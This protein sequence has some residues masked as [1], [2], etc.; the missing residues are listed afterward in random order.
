MRHELSRPQPTNV[1]TVQSLEQMAHRANQAHARALAAAEG[2]VE[3]A[4]AAG[5]AL[6]TAKQIC[7]PGNLGQMVGRQLP[8]LPT[9]RPGLSAARPALAPPGG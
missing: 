4:L 5:Q 3:H 6:L 2:A 7:P 8:R 1:E 9:N